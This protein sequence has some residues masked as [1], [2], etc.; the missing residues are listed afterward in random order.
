MWRRDNCEI[1]AQ[2]Q[3]KKKAFLEINPQQET[4]KLT[5][6]TNPHQNMPDFPLK[7]K[8]MQL[9]KLLDKCG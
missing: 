8:V 2:Q 5:P 1:A 9:F 3:K 4:T 7:G 6:Q